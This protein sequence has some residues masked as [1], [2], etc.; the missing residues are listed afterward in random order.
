MPTLV[1]EYASN[2]ITL[3][4]ILAATGLWKG[5][6]ATMGLLK[7]GGSYSED[8]T[9]AQV[10]LNE[11]TNVEFPGYAAV[12]P[13]TWATEYRGAG[14]AALTDSG[15]LGWTATADLP[16]PLT[17]AGMYISDGTNVAVYLFDTPRQI[18]LKDER[19][20]EAFPFGYV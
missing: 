17:I 9:L 15:L 10:L 7:T 2:K 18:A 4:A 3:A 16:A 1:K 11:P 8:M 6:T 19:I 5:S 20:A 12:T 13:V 14:G